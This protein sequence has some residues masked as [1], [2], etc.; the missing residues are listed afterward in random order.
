MQAC[1]V[2]VRGRDRQRERDQGCGETDKERETKVVGPSER[3]QHMHRTT[4]KRHMRRYRA[5]YKHRL[6]SFWNFPA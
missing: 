2:A 6:P 5:P 4:V 3:I 1:M